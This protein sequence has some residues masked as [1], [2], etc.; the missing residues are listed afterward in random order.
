VIGQK[1]QGLRLK[2][3]LT[4]TPDQS[5]ANIYPFDLTTIFRKYERNSL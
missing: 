1:D 4:L 3:N 5:V 2:E